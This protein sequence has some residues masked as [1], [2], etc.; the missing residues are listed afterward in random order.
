MMAEWQLQRHWIVEETAELKKKKLCILWLFLL[1]NRNEKCVAL[2]E[3]LYFSFHWNQ[4]SKDFLKFNK[5]QIW[6]GETSW[7]SQLKTWGMES[8]K[9]RGQVSY[10]LISLHKDNSETG[11]D[12]INLDYRV[13]ITV[14]LYN[15]NRLIKLTNIFY[16][17]K[18]KP[19]HI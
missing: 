7:R 16:L 9:T 3:R 6:P 14:W 2:V 10:K 4:K 5:C 19:N 13:P 1:Q 8:G 15:S 12:I 11:R 18:H 17:L